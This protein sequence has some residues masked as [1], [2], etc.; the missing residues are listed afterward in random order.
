MIVVTGVIAGTGVTGV[1]GV[2][3]TAIPAPAR[4]VEEAP[5]VATPARPI[6]LGAVTALV[7]VPRGVALTITTM[8]GLNPEV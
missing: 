6:V 7:T 1:T 5:A 8:A 2:G 4:Q 3:A